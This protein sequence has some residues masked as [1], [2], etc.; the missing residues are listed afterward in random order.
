MNPKWNPAV[1][2]S[3]WRWVEGE[4]G[5]DPTRSLSLR[6]DSRTNRN[7]RAARN[8]ASSH[9]NSAL[10]TQVDE[11]GAPL[12][13]EESRCGIRCLDRQ[14]GAA[15]VLSGLPEGRTRPRNPHDSQGFRSREDE[16][17]S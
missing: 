6:V 9:P 17:W 8:V 4:E 11:N 15:R 12:G 3:A 13:R 10:A 14:N 7:D 5:V 2:A 1:L 16:T